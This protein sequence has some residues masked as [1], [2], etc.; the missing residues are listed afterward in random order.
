MVPSN[1]VV[2][3]KLPLTANGKL[4]VRALPL[5]EVV[6]EGDYRA[7]QTPTQRLIADLYG[8]LTGASRVG[9]DDSFFALGGHS[10]LAMR[11]VARIREAL[12]V[13]LPLR[14]LFEAPTVEGL[15]ECLVNLQKTERPKIISGSGRKSTSVP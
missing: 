7:P 14:A 9:L 8:E 4:D 10:L 6:G 2:L 1:F 15:A 12:G 5:P 11:L 13:D 3:E